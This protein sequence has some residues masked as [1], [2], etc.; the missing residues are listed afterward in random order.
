MQRFLHFKI[1]LF[2]ILSLFPCVSFQQ[3]CFAGSFPKLIGGTLGD[4]RLT[5][6]DVDS[7]QNIVAGGHTTDTSISPSSTTSFPSA[8][9]QAIDNTGTFKFMK[10]IDFYK[11]VVGIQYTPDN[12][13]IFVLL[14]SNQLSFVVLDSSNGNFKRQYEF[15]SD[16]LYL[17]SSFVID[18]DKEVFSSFDRVGGYIKIYAF[19]GSQTTSGNYLHRHENNIQHSGFIN[20]MEIFDNPIQKQLIMGGYFRNSTGAKFNGLINFDPTVDM[21][22]NMPFGLEANSGGFQYELANIRSFYNP[23]SMAPYPYINFGCFQILGQNIMFMKFQY[24]VDFSVGTSQFYQTTDLQEQI[25]CRGL[26]AKDINVIYSYIYDNQYNL[27]KFAKID[28]TVINSATMRIKTLTPLNGGSNILTSGVF[29]NENYSYYV[30][31]IMNINI[32]NKTYSKYTGAVMSYNSNQSCIPHTLVD[33][34]GFLTQYNFQVIEI[35]YLPFSTVTGQLS[36]SSSPSYSITSFTIS[37][38]YSDFCT[39]DKLMLYEEGVPDMVFQYTLY[40]GPRFFNYRKISTSPFCA[41][42]TFNN[43]PSIYHTQANSSATK[44]ALLNTTLPG[45]VTFNFTTNK[46]IVNSSNQDEVMIYFV[47]IRSQLDQQTNNTKDQIAQIT[48]INPCLVATITPSTLKTKIQYYRMRNGTQQL[49]LPSFTYNSTVCEKVYELENSTMGGTVDLLF[50]YDNTT[51]VYQLIIDTD[52]VSGTKTYKL[53][54]KSYYLHSNHTQSM[55]TINLEITIYNCLDAQLTPPSFK[56]QTYTIPE[57]TKTFPLSNFT[58]TPFLYECGIIEYYPAIILQGPLETALPS[59]ISFVEFLN[60]LEVQTDNGMN[61]GYHTIRIYGNATDYNLINYYEFTLEIKCKVGSLTVQ[62]IPIQAYG[63]QS[64][65]SQF[66]FE[67]F[68]KTPNCPQS[69]TYTAFE[70]GKSSLPSFISFDA[71]QRQFSVQSNDNQVAKKYDLVVKG[72]VTNPTS[73]STSTYFEEL[74]ITLTVVASTFQPTNQ[75]APTFTVPLVDQIMAVNQ[76]IAYTLPSVT[77]PDGDKY[78]ILVQ[79]GQQSTWILYSQ[80]TLKM[81]PGTTNNGTYSIKIQLTDINKNPMSSTYYLNI[82]VIAEEEAASYN[83]PYQNGTSPSVIKTGFSPTLAAKLN[84]FDYKGFINIEFTT[85]IILP[86]NISTIN[87]NVLRLKIKPSSQSNIKD[88]AF[89]WKIVSLQKRSM[90]L[91]L[92]FTNPEL[93][94]AKVRIY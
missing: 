42:A 24:G 14:N 90:T 47:G 60:N 66:I 41:D 79:L 23:D 78:Q 4:V 80:P 48:F 62:P 3:N 45:S 58:I 33:E 54:F 61:V 44:S 36:H 67:E 38:P 76:Q 83:F 64:P 25:N 30:A 34:E 9:V 49:T 10:M 43:M 17:A 11:G 88:L 2:I 74:N 73:T 65:Q 40:S 26:Y 28:F 55:K 20:Q 59:F 27:F 7:I 81:S 70:Y 57:T 18:S 5:A 6:M 50:G 16:H 91:F 82:Q 37:S 12:L 53:I 22:L 75:G 32:V 13:E 77:D 1:T 46:I 52:Q 21:Q 92:N 39:A 8:I 56:N 94:S 35:P 29:F 19:D 68:I 31:D 87:E 84:S 51:N 93:V 86:T 71:L 89:K 72:E 69:I 85:D 63:I 15:I